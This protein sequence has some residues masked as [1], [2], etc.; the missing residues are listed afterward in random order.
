MR[1]GPLMTS[2]R[3]VLGSGLTR[4][5]C[6]LLELALTFFTWRTLARDAGLKSAAVVETMAQAILA[7]K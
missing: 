2:Y 3:E 4:E 7:A 5:Q 6:A 1:M